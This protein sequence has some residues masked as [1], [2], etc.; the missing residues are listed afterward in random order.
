MA[1]SAKPSARLV[2]ARRL[3]AATVRSGFFPIPESDVLA[4]LE[5]KGSTTL[6]IEALPE[7]APVIVGTAIIRSITARSPT[8]TGLTLD[9]LQLFPDPIVVPPNERIEI[10]LERLP[11]G[12]AIELTAQLGATS[13]TENQDLQEYF[14]NPGP[15]LAEKVVRACG[16]V[17]CLTRI[18]LPASK[19][20]ELVVPILPEIFGE[21]ALPGNLIATLPHLHRLITM[22]AISF[23]DDGSLLL[24]P[25]QLDPGTL[26]ELAPNYQ[27]RQPAAPFTIPKTIFRR[28]RELVFAQPALTGQVDE[29]AN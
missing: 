14:A 28:H 5:L 2:V 27:L 23:R 1:A 19:A 7:A 8:S 12:Y 6:L 9:G 11:E 29:R 16:G 17:C 26:M 18:A 3:T 22:G 13:M 25:Q 21:A 10:G 24:V 4:A 20:N 15:E